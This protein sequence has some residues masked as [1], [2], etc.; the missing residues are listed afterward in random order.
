MSSHPSLDAVRERIARAEIEAQ[1]APGSVTL[2]AVSKTFSTEEIAP[3]IEAG[4][5]VFGENRVQEAK[6]KWPA[7]IETTPGI[8]LHLIGP[9]QTNKV[10]D[11]VQLFDC[12][13]TL[14]R[15]R[16]ADA[17]A[18]EF[19]RTA[20]RPELLVQVNTGSEDQK[21]G[22]HPHE[23]DDFIALCRTQHGLKVSGLMCIPP[24]EEDPA[25]HFALLRK[26][27]GRNGL[28]HLSMGMSADFELAIQFGA[29]HVRA[30]SA[31]FGKRG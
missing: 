10:K 26:I 3:V 6:A 14:D 15:P 1:R 30:G 4:Q 25:P 22:V 24:A 7:L 27:A 19:A 20:R 23:A 8:S 13:H 29:T 2:I 16:L 11:A 17:L 9:L 28:E 5:R 21:A 31:I 12:I 18:S